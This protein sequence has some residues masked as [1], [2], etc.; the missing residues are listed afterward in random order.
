MSE[1]TSPAS[2]FGPSIHALRH[3]NR[4]VV[5][6][7]FDTSTQSP[8]QHAPASPR[9]RPRKHKKHGI[10]LSPII[11]DVARFEDETQASFSP[12]SPRRCVSDSTTY[13][14][15][16]LSSASSSRSPSPTSHIFDE[17]DRTTISS[18][19]ISSGTSP[20]PSLKSPKSPLTVIG[21]T[22]LRAFGIGGASHGDKRDYRRSV[23][24]PMQIHSG[25]TKLQDH[26]K[27]LDSEF[28]RFMSKIHVHRANVLR[29]TLL[30]FLKAEEAEPW[31][32]SYSS[33]QEDRHMLI[34]TK[35]W[36]GMLIAL[37]SRQNSV[38]LSDRPIYLQGIAGV[39]SRPE[40]YVNHS[41]PE[42]QTLLQTTLEYTVDRL[43]Q[44]NVSASLVAFAGKIF[45]LSFF[46]LPGIASR[47]LALWKVPPEVAVR[48]HAEA[49]EGADLAECSEMIME[50]FPLHLR[51][52][53]SHSPSTP[54]ER[55]SQCQVNLDGPWLLRWQAKDNELLFSFVKSYVA[56]ISDIIP[57]SVPEEAYL[58]APGF[59]IIFAHLLQ[60]YDDLVHGT[61]HH[62]HRVSLPTIGDPD[63]SALLLTPEGAAPLGVRTAEDKMLQMIKDIMGE[64][65]CDSL[66]ESVGRMFDAMLRSAA[67][68]TSLYDAEACFVLCD[69]IEGHLLMLD[70][71]HVD[72]DWMFWIDV[73]QKMIAGQHCLTELRGISLL[74]TL[75]EGFSKSEVIR[76]KVCQ[77]WLLLP[78]TWADLY[79]H[80]SPMVR[81]Y[82]MRFVC[83]RI[84][85]D[86]SIS[87][88]SDLDTL[89]TIAQHLKFAASQHCHL[90]EIA[91]LQRTPL[92]LSSI[93]RPAP[94]RKICITAIIPQVPANFL[95][96]F[97]GIVP[98]ADF[99]QDGRC[100]STSPIA[101]RPKKHDP[102]NASLGAFGIKSLESSAPGQ[103]RMGEKPSGFKFTLEQ[104]HP[105]CRDPHE[106]L[107]PTR[108]PQRAQGIFD[109]IS[110]TPLHPPSKT[111]A[112][113]QSPCWKYAGRALA[114]W[115]AIITEYD[116][117][118]AARIL[119]GCHSFADTETPKLMVEWP[120]YFSS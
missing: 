32:P 12:I 84:L 86:I 33:V 39:A 41:R 56:K 20:P 42:Y 101:H 68:R 43:G 120:K 52:L 69:V 79:C 36:N 11:V 109:T 93:S 92:P 108:L 44:R 81:S 45:A 60:V 88:Q 95:L 34:L 99:R 40:W 15:F 17:D 98:S 87:S 105:H 111:V 119:D 62:T 107:L 50:H 100:G 16:Q 110:K 49:S 85:K 104:A 4:A 58:A 2:D 9:E 78:S 24:V 27:S 26:F 30:P 118:V 14:A 22:F 65:K 25:K 112:R 66:N 82:Y 115:H 89:E 59:L 67:K 19:S 18:T 51:S 37:R 106:P 64:V 10:V 61:L 74:Y 63:S 94:N 1:S 114:E 83:W 35:W 73:A 76:R 48:L 80:W 117:F 47:L 53:A 29:A 113:D 6:D 77:D 72:I 31:T 28:A 57:P 38:S 13:T 71:H 116:G 97:D 21:E 54:G 46:Y 102:L 8:S 70:K 75:W 23:S 5:V 103:C 3:P 90:V 7:S 91:H 96:S 55:E